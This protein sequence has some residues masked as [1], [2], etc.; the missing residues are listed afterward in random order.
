MFEFSALGM[1]AAIVP[2]NRRTQRPSVRAEQR[3][4]VHLAGKPDAANLRRLL[5]M[6]C[7]KTVDGG[8][9]SL[10]PGI[11]ILLG[12]QRRGMRQV[13]AVRGRRD[14]R[15]SLVHKHGFHAGRADV[16]SQKHELSS[17]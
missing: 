16:D 15:A 7:G 2:E 6:G 5:R 8:D 12:K 13:E 11:R 9:R 17:P 10:D 4:A 3:G 1:G 14:D